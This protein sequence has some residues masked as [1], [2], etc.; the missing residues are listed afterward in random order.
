M[1][2]VRKMNEEIRRHSA[3]IDTPAE[4]GGDKQAETAK[5]PERDTLGG[6][7]HGREAR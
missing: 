2:E 7:F 1:D 5:P 3:G 6:L 4:D